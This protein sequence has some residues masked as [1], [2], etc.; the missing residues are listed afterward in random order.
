MIYIDASELRVNSRLA[1]HLADLSTLFGN[2]PVPDFVKHCS[3]TNL[4][5]LTGADVMLTPLNLPITGPA[6]IKKHIGAGAIFVQLKFGRDLPGS[7]GERMKES[8][9]RMKSAGARPCQ[10]VLMYV[11]SLSCGK[12]G[13]A[14]INGRSRQRP[15]RKYSGI[16]TA[17]WHWIRRGGSYYPVTRE[18]ELAQVLKAMERDLGA[19]SV[20]EFWPGK[21]TTGFSNDP[22]EELEKIRDWRVA[23][24]NMSTAIGPARATSLMEAMEREG[25]AQNLLQAMAWTSSPK[26]IRDEIGVP[27]MR[28]WGPKSFEAVRK[29]VFGE[30]AGEGFYLSV[31]MMKGEG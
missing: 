27:K 24:A 14:V 4:E 11:G 31:E 7:L 29:V 5:A 17:I 10:C 19:G 25:A 13:W 9:Y 2:Q 15:K 21:I 22:L 16:M 6:L 26:Q 20:T 23:F 3:R 28:L 30:D 18:G 8:L 1:R 12:D